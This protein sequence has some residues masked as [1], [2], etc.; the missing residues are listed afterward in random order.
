MESLFVNKQPIG[1]SDPRYCINPINTRPS[2]SCCPSHMSFN[3]NTHGLEYLRKRKE[4]EETEELPTITQQFQQPFQLQQHQ[5]G[6]EG[7]LSQRHKKVK[8]DLNQ[9][10]E[11]QQQQQQAQTFITPSVDPQS[12]SIENTNAGSNHGG[13]YLTTTNASIYVDSSD[14][15]PMETSTDSSLPNTTSFATEEKSKPD[16]ISHLVKDP[17]SLKFMIKIPSPRHLRSTKGKRKRERE[18]ERKREKKKVAVLV[19]WD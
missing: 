9:Q 1:I 8:I 19:E 4:V 10:Y 12:N 11:Q 5:R 13:N 6:K 2:P 14:S 16:V 7:P 18:R 17:S 15:M 3:I